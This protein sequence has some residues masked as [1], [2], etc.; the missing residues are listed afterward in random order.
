VILGI[1]LIVQ[2]QTG[3]LALVTVI[4]AFSI[5]WGIV[6]NILSLPVKA[7]ASLALS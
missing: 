7:P 1:L 5:A 4:G 6:L 2:P 3:A